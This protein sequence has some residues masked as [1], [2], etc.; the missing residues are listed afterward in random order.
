MHYTDIIPIVGLI[1]IILL[2]ILMKRS[3]KKHPEKYKTISL[4]QVVLYAFMGALGL[5]AIGLFLKD[6]LNKL[7]DFMTPI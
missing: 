5:L 7:W 2:Y 6:V 1:I 3:Q 4:K